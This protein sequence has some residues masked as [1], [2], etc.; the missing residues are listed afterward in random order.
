MQKYKK[1]PT[2]KFKPNNELIKFAK[3]FSKNFKK[4]GEGDY[5]SDGKKKYK[6]RYTNGIKDSHRERMLSTFCRVSIKDKHMEFDRKALRKK[7]IHI[8]F[9]FFLILWCIARLKV[10]SE[11]EADAITV[12]YYFTTGRSFIPVLNGWKKQFF[13]SKFNNKMNTKRF[14]EMI[15]LVKQNCKKNKIKSLK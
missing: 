11:F 8:D 2:V 7:D 1:M 12:K 5:L 14:D 9:V 13:I 4:I 3:K 15:D 6:I 10:K